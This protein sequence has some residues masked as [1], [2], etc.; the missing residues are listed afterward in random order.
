MH[1][2]PLGDKTFYACMNYGIDLK[3]NWA[4][5][6]DLNCLNL[7]PCQRLEF[8]TFEKSDLHGNNFKDQRLVCYLHC[9][10]FQLHEGMNQ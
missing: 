7:S 8:H 4:S 10:E 1:K 3:C 2:V 6:A 5:P 9:D